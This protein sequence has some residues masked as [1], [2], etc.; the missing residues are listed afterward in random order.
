LVSSRSGSRQRSSYQ[1]ALGLVAA[2]VAIALRA[3]P[4]LCK[5]S[6]ELE[7]RVYWRLTD[8]WLELTVRFI[9]EET[10]VRGLKDRISRDVLAAF[11]E[12]GLGMASTN[13]EIVGLPPLRVVRDGSSA[14]PK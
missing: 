4:A 7:P 6:T 9:A 10:G 2:G 5:E 8:N 12:A 11:D 1:R 3:A 14:D 13:Y